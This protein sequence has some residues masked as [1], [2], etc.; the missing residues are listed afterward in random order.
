MLA[1]KPQIM[2]AVLPGLKGLVGPKTVSL[3]VAAGK[4]ISYFE[5]RLGGA[6][7][8]PFRTH[9]RWSGAA[10]PARLQTPP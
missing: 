2:D 3:S 8:G 4:T 9:R 6:W 10:L 1:V 7:S 5:E